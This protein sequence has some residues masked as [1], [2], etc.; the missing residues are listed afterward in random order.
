MYTI[1]EKQVSKNVCSP[2]NDFSD[3]EYN[4]MAFIDAVQKAY[5]NVLGTTATKIPQTTPGGQQLVDAVEKVAIQFRRAG[6]FAP[7]FWSSPD[8][9]GDLDTFNRNIE[10]EGFY[11]L[12]GAFADQPQAD[13]QNRIAPVMQVAVKNAG[14]IH[15]GS[16]IINFNL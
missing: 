2:A 4:L 13:R 16:I 11:I 14:A 7:G 10:A 8:F 5:F 9:F 6:V 15:R 12:L 3:N 1:F